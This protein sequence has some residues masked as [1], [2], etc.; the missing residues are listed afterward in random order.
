VSRRYARRSCEPDRD[1]NCILPSIQTDQNGSFAS[2]GSIGRWRCPQLAKQK[3][4][5]PIYETVYLLTEQWGPL[6]R[7][8]GSR[9]WLQQ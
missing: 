3:R 6:Q 5:V 7:T 8:P 4:N 9:Y 2:A 1:V